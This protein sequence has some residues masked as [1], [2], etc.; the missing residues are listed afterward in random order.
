MIKFSNNIIRK[1]FHS[2]ALY[3]NTLYHISENKARPKL[4][5]DLAYSFYLLDLL[6]T[7]SK[8]LKISNGT[9]KITVFD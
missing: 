8:A 5:F 1:A 3:T 6:L 7:L 2:D 9:A 4:L